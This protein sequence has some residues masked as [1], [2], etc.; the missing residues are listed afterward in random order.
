M[1]DVIGSKQIFEQTRPCLNILAVN[2]KIM[3]FEHTV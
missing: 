3:T 2:V 1:T